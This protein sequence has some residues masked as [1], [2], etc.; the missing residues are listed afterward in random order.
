MDSQSP[1][2]QDNEKSE[3]PCIT[4]LVAWA[5]V[6]PGERGVIALRNIKAG[7]TVECSPVVIGKAEDF[8]AL[9][10]QETPI[11]DHLLLWEEKGEGVEFAMGLGYLMI[12]NHDGE[13][14]A[15]FSYDYPG[16]TISVVAQRDIKA[17]EELTI[18]YED[19]WFEVR[20]C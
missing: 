17:G 13:P 6:A 14:N 20:K 2:L 16:R 5:Y 9:H 7:E 10:G 19:P 11:D 8:Q 4:G 1:L 18:D 3:N 12:Y 15:K